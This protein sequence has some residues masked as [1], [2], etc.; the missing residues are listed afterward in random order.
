MLVPKGPRR[1]GSR[2]LKV[3]EKEEVNSQGCGSQDLRSG[4][5]GASLP[6]TGPRFP[7][8]QNEGVGLDSC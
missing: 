8:E 1:I 7:P 5:L 3:V 2:L 6:F 4:N